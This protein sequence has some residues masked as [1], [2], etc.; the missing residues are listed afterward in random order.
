MWINNLNYWGCNQYIVQ[1]A[2]G[3]DL[4]TGAQWYFVCRLSEVVGAGDCSPSR[5]CG[6]CAVPNGMFQNEMIDAAVL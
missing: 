5:N 2:L 3:A 4:K 6:L 1:R